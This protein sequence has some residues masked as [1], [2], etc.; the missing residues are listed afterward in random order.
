M[1]RSVYGELKTSK[2]F[3]NIKQNLFNQFISGYT[4]NRGTQT[5]VLFLQKY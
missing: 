4:P 5:Q 3:D 1:T 2:K